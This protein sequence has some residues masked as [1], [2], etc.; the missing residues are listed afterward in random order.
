MERIRAKKAIK[1]A[2]PINWL[3]RMPFTAPITLRT[4]TSL[5]RLT[6]RA[7]AKFMKLMQAMI[8][9]TMATMEKIRT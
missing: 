8:K 2:S 6:D 7:V 4:P 9:M 3:I 5:A 1:I